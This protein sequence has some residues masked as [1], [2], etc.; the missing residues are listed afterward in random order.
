MVNSGVAQRG[1]H[2]AKHNYH[3]PDGPSSGSGKD[4]D[5]ARARTAACT[6]LPPFLTHVKGGG[7]Y[8]GRLE[9]LQASMET[10]CAAARQD[11]VLFCNSHDGLQPQ[12]QRNVPPAGRQLRRG[13]DARKDRRMNCGGRNTATYPGR[14]RKRHGDRSGMDR[15]PMPGMKTPVHG[16][17]VHLPQKAAGSTIDGPGTS[18]TA[19]HGLIAGRAAAHDHATRV[20]K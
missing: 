9:A 10:I 17:P 4:W 16:H 6:I 5:L 14:G 18:P 19:Y 12:L 2:H 8:N 11:Y 15:P 13:A 3:S 7:V 20:Y 1:R